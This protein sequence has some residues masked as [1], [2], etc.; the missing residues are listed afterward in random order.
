MDM[1]SGLTPRDCLPKP[2]IRQ[3]VTW[4]PED[5]S[6]VHTCSLLGTWEELWTRFWHPE[7]SNSEVGYLTW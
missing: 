5:K 6:T 1:S 7:P 3:Q 4:S 2:F